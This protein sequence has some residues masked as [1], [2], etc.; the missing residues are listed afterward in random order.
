MT[1][2]KLLSFMLLTPFLLVGCSTTYP[3]RSQAGSACEEWKA[4]GRELTYNIKERSDN[5][6]W[7]RFCSL[8]ADTK[9]VLG[10][11]WNSVGEE[12]SSNHKEEVKK[13]FRY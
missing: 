10:L 2:L 12:W 4:K 8:E 3:S 11:E 6:K 13:N 1:K 9:Q 7:S 5:S